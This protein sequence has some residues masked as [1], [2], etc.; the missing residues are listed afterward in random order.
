[1]PK[2]TATFVARLPNP[3]T[4]TRK[5]WDTE[6]RGFGLFAGKRSKTWYFQRDF[7][8]QT[9]RVLIGRY[10][11]ISA[12]AA[13]TLALDMSRGAGKAFQTGAPTLE[14]AM[15]T[16]LGRPKLRS[17]A[18]KANVRGYLNN[19]LRDWM[20]LPL[21]EITRSMVVAR[22]G[23]LARI[24]VGANHMFRALRSIW[25]HARRTHDLPEAP[26]VAIE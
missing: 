19:H 23:Q 20:R 9:R 26:I 12:A 1:V 22:H 10:P 14:W 17:D 2:L 13:L 18:F 4:G 5:H 21:D 8:G 24:P 11:V 3:A 15:E 25:N 6:V 7:G 16:Y